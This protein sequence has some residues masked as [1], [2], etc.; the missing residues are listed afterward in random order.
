M[1]R[2]NT[3]AAEIPPN[4]KLYVFSDGAFEIVAADGREWSIDDLRDIIAAPE[5]PG[6]PEP[7]RIWA[8]VRKF[9]RPG[10][11]DDDF[12]VLTVTFE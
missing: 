10:P 2:W 12:S 1:G 9:A 11:L 6:V 7:R 8:K 3:G 5:E 4:T